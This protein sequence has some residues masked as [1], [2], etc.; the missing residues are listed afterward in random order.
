MRI[1]NFDKKILSVLQSNGTASNQELAENVGLSASQCSRRRIQ[2]EA[3][4]HIE[5]YRARLNPA[6]LGLDV[7]AFIGVSLAHHTKSNLEQFHALV[8]RLQE[9]Q[10][11]HAM[12][13]D[14]DY[15]IKVTVANLGALSAFINDVLLPHPAVQQ[16]RSNIVLNSI[17]RDGGLPIPD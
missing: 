2:L 10:E 13:G 5:G 3:N 11:A 1:D 14:F 15:I 17:K 16:V 7:T 9:V 8:D 12:T 4:G 6:R